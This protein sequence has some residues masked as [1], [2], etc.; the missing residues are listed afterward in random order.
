LFQILAKLFNGMIKPFRTT[1]LEA[2][3]NISGLNIVFG[4]VLGF[5]LASTESMGTRDYSITL[6]YSATVAIL[7]LYISHSKRRLIYTMVSIA[8]VA[9]LPIFLGDQFGSNSSTIPEKLQPTFA[10]WLV[11]TIMM[12]F[13]PRVQEVVVNKDE[14]DAEI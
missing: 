11:M 14:D 4:A 5:V 2:R 12:E 8:F 9:G 13:W 6:F 7:I 1:A 3:A 10:V